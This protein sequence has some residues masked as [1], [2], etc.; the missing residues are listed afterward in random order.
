[1]PTASA[2]WPFTARF[3][4]FKALNAA[5]AL[6]LALAALAALLRFHGLADKPLWYNEIL[7]LTRARLPLDSLVIDALTHKHYPT[8]FLLLRPFASAHISEW[9]LRFPSAVFGTVCVFLVTRSAIEI[10]G[11]LAGLVAGLLMALS[12]LAVQFGQEARPYTLISCSV[13][14]AVWGLVCIARESE[15]AAL[16]F[17]RPDALRGPWLA[18]LLG[19][20]GAL[21]VEN[22]TI[23]WLIAS[24]IAFLVIV[25]RTASARSALLRNWAWTQAAIALVWLP[26]LIIMY[27]ANRGAALTGLEWVPQPTWDNIRSIIAAVYMF[28][29]SDMMTFGLLPAPLPQFGVA[30][31]A[32]VL[33]GAWRLKSQPNLLAVIGLAFVAMP[34]TILLISI[35]QP[36]LVPRYLLWSTGPFFLMAGIG[37]AALPARFSPAITAAVA[38]GGAVSL[39]PY[40]S[41][42]TKPRWDQVAAYLANNLRPQGV[43]VAEYPAVQ[44]IVTS[45]AE[46]FHFESKFDVL[47]WRAHR[48][49]LLVADGERKW[50][51]YGRVGQGAQ[52]S[53][54][55]FRH[56]WAVL[57]NP[58]AEAR[59]GSHIL[60]LRFDKSTTP[61]QQSL[62]SAPSVIVQRAVSAPNLDRMKF[63]NS[64]G[65]WQY[66]IYG[67]R[68]SCAAKS[69]ISAWS[70]PITRFPSLSSRAFSPADMLLGTIVR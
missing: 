18:Y 25:H 1:M 65:S 30:V 31:V 5:I 3:T 66:Q 45:Y 34:V 20:I 57:G 69:A 29:L 42:E 43:I 52:E 64:N 14:V 26:A 46:P 12:P 40:Y 50:I 36:V 6:P 24:N 61:P 15:A 9:A 28:R 8:Y 70:A 68:G 56:K 59:F 32:L 27:S 60:I 48:S 49:P 51:L 33:F 41:S 22:N 63:S 13:L 47:A 38:M 35:F 44:T 55:E 4:D 67:N 11:A 21:F 10:G 17:S 2:K 39:W 7:S 23:P 62:N 16:P 54:E 58:A 53:E 37:V 19:T